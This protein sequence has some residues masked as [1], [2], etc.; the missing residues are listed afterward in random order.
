MRGR[1]L[2]PAP[3]VALRAISRFA[4]DRRF[5]ASCALRAGPKGR[6]EH[7]IEERF[8]VFR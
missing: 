7:M 3:S 5:A 8:V 6:V 1:S 2:T 4:Q